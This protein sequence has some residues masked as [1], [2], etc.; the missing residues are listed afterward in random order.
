MNF[1]REIVLR[2]A[3]FD[4]EDKLRVQHSLNADGDAAKVGRTS[5]ISSILKPSP[6]R[7][8]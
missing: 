7:G 8:I 3:E 2:K 5:G 4:R 6:V 1:H